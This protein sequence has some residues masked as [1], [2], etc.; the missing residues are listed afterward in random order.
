M[1]KKSE[2]TLKHNLFNSECLYMGCINPEIVTA[3]PVPPH[4]GCDIFTP[5]PW[6]GGVKTPDSRD[7]TP[8]PLL[9]V[10]CSVF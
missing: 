1:V 5:S 6:G 8:S 7:D 9:S 4:P 3:V 2:D 10:I